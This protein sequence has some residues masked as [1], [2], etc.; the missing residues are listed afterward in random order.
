[1]NSDQSAA[2]ILPGATI[3]VLGSGQPGR[4]FAIAAK[5]MGYRVVAFSPSKNSPAGQV[6]DVEFCAKYDDLDAVEDFAKQVAVTTLEFENVLLSTIDAAKKFTLVRP[7]RRVLETT[8]HRLKEKT[9]L[10]DAGI[11][12][13]E[14]RPVTNVTELQSAC[15]SFLPSVVKTALSGYDGKGQVVLREKS[16]IANAWELLQ[17]DNAIL[18]ELVDLRSEFSIVGARG[19]NGESVVYS[20]IKNVHRNHILDV[21]TSPFD[22]GKQLVDEAEQIAHTIME[23]LGAIGVLCV[24]FFLCPDGRLLVNEIAP[25]AHNSGHLSIEAHVTSQFEQQVRSICGLNLGSTHQI[26]PAA[27][28]NLLEDCWEHGTPKWNQALS[29]PNVKLH[30]YGKD[31]PQTGRKMGHLTATADTLETATTNALAARESLSAAE[32]PN[33]PAEQAGKSV[34][35]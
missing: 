28:V 33:Q 22:L 11:P 16:E 2:P 7:G 17:T 32:L 18:E 10:R 27:M 31:S 4:M 21:S 19:P 9:F 6:A 29:Y 34:S 12:V 1:M 24:E 14:F 20:P 23:E 30:L 3:G 13:A 15:D 5:Q 26:K 25:R 8:Q 35:A